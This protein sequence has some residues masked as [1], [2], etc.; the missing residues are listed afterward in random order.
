[1]TAMVEHCWP[2]ANAP[3]LSRGDPGLRLTFRPQSG[4]QR[5]VAVFSALR[6]LTVVRE[7]LPQ[8]SELL[9]HN[10]DVF[11]RKA[12][13]RTHDPQRVT[14]RPKAQVCSVGVILGRH[15][16]AAEVLLVYRDANS[17]AVRNVVASS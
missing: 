4:Y 8:G 5:N 10:V 3:K 15:V 13:S 9:P 2:A 14:L 7:P 12:I 1:M 17:N 6:F 11:S 16:E